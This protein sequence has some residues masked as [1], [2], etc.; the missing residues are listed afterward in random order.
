MLTTLKIRQ[1]ICVR[2]FVLGV[3]IAGMCAIATG[4]PHS[5][6]YFAPTPVRSTQLQVRA[7]H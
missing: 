1:A 5:K 6:G 3:V 2:R 7:L 4:C